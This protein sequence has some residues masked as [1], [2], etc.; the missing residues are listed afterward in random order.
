MS[1]TLF[2]IAED[3]E[4]DSSYERLSREDDD[5]FHLDGRGGRLPLGPLTIGLRGLKPA[6]PS[7]VCC[8]LS[9][10]QGGFQAS[11]AGRLEKLV[12]GLMLNV[13]NRNAAY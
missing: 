9:S 2:C 6:A 8:P 12:V 3:T 7:H 1:S 5:E 4:P 11:Q 13:V 10:S